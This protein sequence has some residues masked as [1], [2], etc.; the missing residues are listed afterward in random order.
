[1]NGYKSMMQANGYLVGGE[2]VVVH[3]I[4]DVIEHHRHFGWNARGANPDVA[5]GLTVLSGP[6]SSVRG[7]SVEI[8]R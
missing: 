2:G 3:P 1:M 6:L 4:S 8:L 5:F 7:V